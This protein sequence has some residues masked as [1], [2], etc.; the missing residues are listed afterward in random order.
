[1]TRRSSDLPPAKVEL[2]DDQWREKLTPEEFAVLRQAGTERP[3]VGEYTDTHTEG[4]YLAA[5]VV[6]NCSAA[7]RNSIRTA[8]GRRSSTRR[9]PTP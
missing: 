8:V 2:T 6:P 4:V 5:H 3:G 7:Q 9:I 1:M